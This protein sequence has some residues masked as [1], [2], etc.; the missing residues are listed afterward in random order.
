M[1]FS[2][3]FAP[4]CM[5]FF[6]CSSDLCCLQRQSW[7]VQT[8]TTLLCL[9]W[10]TPPNE[11]LA[12]PIV[13]AVTKAR[14]RWRLPIWRCLEVNMWVSGVYSLHSEFALK[15]C[16]VQTDQLDE[17]WMDSADRSAATGWC[18]VHGPRAWRFAHRCSRRVQ[19]S[20]LGSRFHWSCGCLMLH[21][22]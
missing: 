17:K 19:Y 15:H 2:D 21:H 6:F 9:W 5:C 14:R 3:I 22:Q 18:E 16:H 10:L 7:A 8:K 11:W 1:P 4:L 12:M 20:I 13:A